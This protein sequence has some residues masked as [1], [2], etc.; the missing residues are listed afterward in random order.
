MRDSQKTKCH[1]II[2]GAA[3]SAGAIG[4]G[5]AQL[6]MADNFAITPIQVGMVVA[7]GKVFGKSITDGVAQGVLKAAMGRAIGRAASQ[8][9]LGWI[10]GLGN[11][12]NASTA[13]AITERIGW[14]IAEKFDND[15][16]LDF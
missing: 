5:L 10:P 1:A 14:K 15:E 2:H 9:L 12:I 4:G 13:F 6:P 11:T 16:S 7:L 3:T 8:V